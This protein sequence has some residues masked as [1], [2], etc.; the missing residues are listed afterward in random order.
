MVFK[1]LSVI[2]L[3]GVTLAVIKDHDQMQCGEGKG[4]FH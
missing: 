4:L 1:G 3:A 2:G